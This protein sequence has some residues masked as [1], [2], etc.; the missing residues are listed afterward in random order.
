MS[1]RHTSSGTAEEPAAVHRRDRAVTAEVQAPAARLGVAGDDARPSRSSPTR[2]ASG[3]SAARS[4]HQQIATNEVRRRPPGRRRHTRHRAPVGSSIQGLDEAEQRCLHLAGDHAVGAIGE[5]V[6][7]VQARVEPEEAHVA[8]GVR[9]ADARGDAE[10]DAERGVH[11]HRDGGHARGRGAGAVER[12]HGD[13]EQ[14][15][16]VPARLQRGGG[17]GHAQRL[18]TQLVARD[19]EDGP[20]RSH[21]RWPAPRGTGRCNRV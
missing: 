8:A 20:G 16:P 5:E 1:A 15:R 17:P 18:V 13:V 10:A 12:V 9:R 14:R 19:E 11:R 6:V 3:G 4:R 21:G 7:G 2:A